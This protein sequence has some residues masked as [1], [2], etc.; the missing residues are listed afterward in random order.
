MKKIVSFL[1]ALF[2]MLTS[3]VNL[4]AYAGETGAADNS[5]IE[6]RFVHISSHAESLD[7]SGIT[8]T[9]FASVSAKSR[10]KITIN[11]YLQKKEGTTYI[12]KRDWTATGTGTSL[13]IEKKPV[14]DIAGKYRL[15]FTIRSAMSNIRLLLINRG[16]HKEPFCH[17]GDC[18][19]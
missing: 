7:K 9:C 19:L 10:C 4:T 8:A 17:S 13:S 2:I 1:V 3:V 18:Q 15:K 5:D 14:I 12:T 16:I 6:Q 11:M